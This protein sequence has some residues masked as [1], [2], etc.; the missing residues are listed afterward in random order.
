MDSCNSNS[1]FQQWK[2]KDSDLLSIQGK[3]LYF[4]YGNTGGE[5]VLHKGSELFSH[6]IDYS[7]NQPLCA[8]GSLTFYY[9]CYY[10][11]W[12]ILELLNL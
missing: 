2:C 5:I 9:W 8:K 10:H 4:N 3:E 1:S 11:F 6:W 7:T 12:I